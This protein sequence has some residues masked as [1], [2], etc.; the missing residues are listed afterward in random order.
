M[1]DPDAVGVELQLD[2]K[3]EFQ[4]LSVTARVEAMHD[5]LATLRQALERNEGEADDSEGVRMIMDIAHQLLP[6]IE[7]DEIPLDETVVIEVAPEHPIEN[8][9]ATPDTPQ[10]RRFGLPALIAQKSHLAIGSADHV[11]H[12]H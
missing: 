6:H 4:A 5:Y 9:L 8:L 11:P 1:N 12:M 7:A 3:P 2:F 10:D